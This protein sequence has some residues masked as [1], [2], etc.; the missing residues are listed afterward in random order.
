MFAVEIVGL[1]KDYPVGFWRQRPKRALDGLNL[2]V[3]ASEI[4]GL[5]GPNGAGKSTTLKILLRL[6]FPTSGTA[7]ILG[8]EV[9]D[10][11]LHARIGYLPENPYFYD[12]LTAEEF[13]NYA[14][15]LF[16]LGSAERRRRVGE[17]LE[18]VDLVGSRNV[19]LGKFSKGMVQRLGIAQALINDPDVLF[20]DEPMSGLDPLGRREVRDLM[21]ELRARGKTVFFSTHILSDAEAL[22]D[23]VAILNQ[24]R[25]EGTGELRHILSLGVRSTEVVLEDPAPDVLGELALYAGA[26]VRTGDEVRFSL[27]P[28]CDVNKVLDLALAK[29]SQI[30]SVNPVRMSLEDYFVARVGGVNQRL[31]ARN[32]KFERSKVESRKSKSGNGNSKLE[33]GN[34]GVCVVPVPRSAKDLEDDARTRADH[35]EAA[36]IRSSSLESRSSSSGFRVS[37]SLNRLASIALHTFKESVRDK[38]LYSLIVFALLLIGA[39]ILFGTISVGIEQIILVNL[40][41]SSISVIGLLMAVFVGIGLVSKEIE[42][43]SINNILSKPVW[44]AEF[45]VGKYLG[46]LLTL[47]VNTGIMTVGFYFALF[48]QKR[49]LGAGDFGALGAIYLILLELAL[50]VGV[51]LLFSTISTPTPSAVYTLALYVTANISSAMRGLGRATRNPVVERV[52]GLLYYLLPNFSDFNVISRVAHGERIPGYL[53]ISNSLYALLY[54]TILVSAAIVIFEERQFR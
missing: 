49:S 12:Y 47:A 38:V 45:I 2:R 18:R 11:S 7:R 48:C 14:G 51:A 42:R 24:G 19:P 26:L 29:G 53:A 8:R 22:C 5:L 27:T 39:S 15:E 9:D 36:D 23:R 50:V 31:E 43:R 1:T 28:E 37:D 10:V 33:T 3:E 30:V 44:R 35:T 52:A 34:A 6:V 17:L 13:L 25:L 32:P 16:G 21:L 54:A 46:L 4:F 41:L 40:S 20:L